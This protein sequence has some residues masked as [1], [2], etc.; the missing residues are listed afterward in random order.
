MKIKTNNKWL[1]FQL[2]LKQKHKTLSRQE[3]NHLA[4]TIILITDIARQAKESN[5][6]NIAKHQVHVPAAINQGAMHP[7]M[8]PFLEEEV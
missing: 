4:K 6:V 8:K 2:T 7:Q 5:S 3:K 1:L